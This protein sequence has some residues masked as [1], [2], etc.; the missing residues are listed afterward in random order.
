[1]FILP[2]PI[3]ERR[4]ARTRSGTLRDQRFPTLAGEIKFLLL[5]NSRK[6]F[7]SSLQGSSLKKWMSL[8]LHCQRF[9]TQGY[10]GLFQPTAFTDRQFLQPFN[11]KLAGS[12]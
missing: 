5:K 2:E 3:R 12:F 8:F 10:S 9:Q 6:S 7:S 1:M 11:Q 4:Q